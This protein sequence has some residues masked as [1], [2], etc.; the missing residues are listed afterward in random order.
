[1]VI[2]FKMDADHI[3]VDHI[4]VEYELQDYAIVSWKML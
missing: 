2:S 4:Y 3:Y 1:M